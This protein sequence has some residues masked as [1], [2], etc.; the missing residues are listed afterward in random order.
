MVYFGESPKVFMKTVS[1]NLRCDGILIKHAKLLIVGKWKAQ[2]PT[3]RRRS[4]K[5]F[6]F[7]KVIIDIQ[8][9]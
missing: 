2:P 7:H 1:K 3:G 4:R 8:R 6:G 5:P 9:Q